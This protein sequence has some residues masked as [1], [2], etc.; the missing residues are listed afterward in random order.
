MIAREMFE[1]FKARFGPL[2]LRAD[3]PS[4]NRLFVFVD[5]SVVKHVCHHIFRELDAR[6]VASIGSDD[7]PFS[8]TFLVAHNF[9]FD[10]DHVLCSILTQLPESD[11]KID[12]ITS[13]VPAASW[14]EREMRDLL[15]IEP[16]GHRYLKRL[17]LPDG[18][19][20]G[21]HPL[22]KDVPWDQVPD[23]Y[24]EEREFQ[25]DEP[26]EGCTVVPFGPFHPTLDEPAHFRLYVEGE[27][28]RGCEYRGFMVHRGIEKLAESVMSY[29]DIPM[30]AERI[31]GIC[32]CVHNV[33]YA[34]AVEEAA[35]LKPPPRAEYIRTIMLE[36]ERLHSHLLWVGL[37]CH[38]VGFDTLFMQSFRI[39]EPIMWIAEKISGNRKTYA[40]CLVGGVRRDLTH[41]LKT[42]L[43]AVLDKLESE[44]RAVVNAVS[45]DKN[46]QKRTRDVGVADKALVKSAGLLGPVARAAGVD[47]DCRRDHPYAAY[48]RVDFDVITAA[49]RRRVGPRRGADE[50]SIRIH[51]D[52]SP[53]PGQDGRGPAP[54]GD[55]RRVADRA[56]GVV[57]GRGA[58]GRE[59]SLRHHRRKQSPAPLASPRA[60]LSE[61][62]GHTGHD[63][64]S[65]DR[66]HD[67]F[68][69]QY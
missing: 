64:R 3:L 42:E 62:A 52:H 65:A 67:H 27:M 24:D 11:P 44:W 16:V 32:G 54:T 48:D 39:R 20:E 55:Q 36:I 57:V 12:S 2:I 6:Y 9:A 41:E 45:N 38:I 58:A 33:A 25:F 1:E 43:R 17:V 59:P 40:L 21:K 35:V 15:G 7:R 51:Q 10:K 5:R 60:D 22:R 68:P 29:N 66:R 18:W 4:D 13:L 63:Q 56:H 37:A 30:L 26:P 50:G 31:C 14:A 49:E 61:P 34:Q 8:G 46:I 19:P 53:M 28:V 69:G 47:I 23:G